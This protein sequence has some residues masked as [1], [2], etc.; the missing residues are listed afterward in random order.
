MSIDDFAEWKGWGGSD[1]RNTT[2]VS[3]PWTIGAD[4]D[5]PAVRPAAKCWQNLSSDQ[6]HCR[7]KRAD[8]R[9]RS[10][11]LSDLLPLQKQGIL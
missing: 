2:R 4:S 8:L 11:T 5:Q 1:R 9:D 3:S 10:F 6:N 7:S